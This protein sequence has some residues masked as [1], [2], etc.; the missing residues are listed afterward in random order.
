VR[1]KYTCQVAEK[2]LK[3]GHLHWYRCFSWEW[4]RVVTMLKNSENFLYQNSV[5]VLFVYIRVSMAINKRH[6][7]QLRTFKKWTLLFHW[8]DKK[9]ENTSWQLQPAVLTRKLQ[10]FTDNMRSTED[11]IFSPRKYISLHWQKITSPDL[12]N[13]TYEEIDVSA[14]RHQL[15]E[16]VP[17]LNCVK[18]FPGKSCETKQSYTQ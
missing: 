6:Y 13:Q 18:L 17:L 2:N 8:E 12:R 16:V 1:P 9:L 3:N 5:I 7:F 4:H 15:D 10:L 14:D 11:E